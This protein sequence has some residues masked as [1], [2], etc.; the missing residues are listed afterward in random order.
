MSKLE[1]MYLYVTMSDR[2]VWRIPVLVIAENRAA[3]YAEV[4]GVYFMD[5]LE[6]DTRPLFEA[7]DYE[8][9]DWACN[10]MNWS[11]VSPVAVQVDAPLPE[12]NYQRDWT[13]AEMEVLES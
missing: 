13:N 3:A 8:I 5:S 12:S 9:T 6:N 10:N 2:T 11:D 7:D 4:D 1:D